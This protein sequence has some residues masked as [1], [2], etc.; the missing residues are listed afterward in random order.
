M[1]HAKAQLFAWEAHGKGVDVH[2]LA[3]PTK[4]ELLHKEYQT[5]KDQFKTE[6]KGSI[7]DKYGGIEHLDAPP[8]EL[9][10]AQTEDYVE[11][12][13]QGKIIKG[14]ETQKVHSKYDE[15]VYD[16]NHTAVWG[17]FWKDGTWG[18][19]CCHSFVKNSYC[20]G[21]KGVM[22]EIAGPSAVAPAIASTSS[23]SRAVSEPAD[24]PES[25]PSTSTSEAE[26]NKIA[27][28]RERDEES[29]R[30]QREKRKRKKEAA[31]LKRLSKKRRKKK[32]SSSESSSCDSSSSDSSDDE[33]E[34]EKKQRKLKKVRI[35]LCSV[36]FLPD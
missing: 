15:D 22:L 26:L 18:Y 31:R 34:E 29:K 20:T 9:L 16:N 1:N 24:E 23:T 28:E 4:L 11:Y 8:K 3:D 12:S 14:G 21:E 30:K 2:N 17:S 10:L 7:L 33:D 19:K 35:F 32:D 25:E 36:D 6:V 27:G 5:K 13:R